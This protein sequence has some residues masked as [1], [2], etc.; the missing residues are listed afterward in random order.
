M[1]SFERNIC[2]DGEPLAKYD[3]LGFSGVQSE[4]NYGDGGSW[5][6]GM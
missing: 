3:A 5:R 6:V 4:L 2:V 1:F